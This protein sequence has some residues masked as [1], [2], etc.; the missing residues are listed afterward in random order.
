VH[1]WVT[2]SA[3]K[4]DTCTHDANTVN[5]INKSLGFAC[6]YIA[7]KYFYTHCTDLEKKIM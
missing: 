6:E 1:F 2:Q 4:S 5:C 3:F 7:S